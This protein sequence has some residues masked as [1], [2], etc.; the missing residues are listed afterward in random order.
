MHSRTPPLR[1]RDGRCTTFGLLS[2]RTGFRLRPLP[3]LELRMMLGTDSAWGSGFIGRQGNDRNPEFISTFTVRELNVAYEV[4]RAGDVALSFRMGRQTFAIGGV[5]RDYILFDWLDAITANLEMGR[6]G[7]V[8]ALL[9]DLYAGSDL[10]DTV[11]FIGYQADRTSPRGFRGQHNTFRTGLVY[12][13]N[14]LVDGLDLRAYYFFAKVGANCQGSY[15]TGTDMSYCGQLGNFPD[16]DYV[17]ITGLRGSYTLRWNEQAT[18]G[19]R[20]SQ[21]FLFGEFSQSFGIDRKEALVRDVRTVGSAFGAGV[22]VDIELPGAR[23]D[24][25]AEG[26]WFQGSRYASD[27]LQYE[28]GYVGFKGLRVGGLTA[29]AL[30]GWRPSAFLGPF[31]IDNEPHEIVRSGGM[32]FLHAGVGFEVNRTSVMFDYYHYRDTSSSFVSDFPVPID[33][34]LPSG[35]PREEVDAQERLGRMLGNEL[36]VRVMHRPVD[37]FAAYV[38]AGVLLPGAFYE[39]ETPRLVGTAMAGDDRPFWAIRAGTAMNL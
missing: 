2:A 30:S 8:R 6:G 1:G 18:S 20:P 14:R 5:P 38:E 24:L 16:N 26:Y 32:W 23:I 37:I 36:N 21:A 3:E 19:A 7:R 33:F 29:G 11:Y 28:H 22:D 34:Q 31:G 4:F 10:P 25:L 9:F 39:I 13:N 27:G 15:N 12:E 17:Q 35:Y